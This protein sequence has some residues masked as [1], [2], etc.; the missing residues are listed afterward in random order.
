MI[1]DTIKAICEE[2]GISIT[3]LE[4][5]AGLT[6]GSISKWNNHVPQADRLQAVAKVLKVKMEKLLNE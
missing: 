3:Q 1:Y 4:K 2:K 5:Q 6:N